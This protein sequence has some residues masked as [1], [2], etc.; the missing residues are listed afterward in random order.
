[1]PSCNVSAAKKSAISGL[2]KRKSVTYQKREGKPTGILDA[3]FEA[4][5]FRVKDPYVLGVLIMRQQKECRA[6]NFFRGRCWVEVGESRK[7]TSLERPDRVS[8]GAMK[9]NKGSI[10]SRKAHLRNGLRVPVSAK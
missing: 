10:C 6:G 3:C 8:A 1:L 2:R 9:N 7:P 4:T 5:C